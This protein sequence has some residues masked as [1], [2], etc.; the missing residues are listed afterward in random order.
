[1]NVT[2]N[3]FFEN[4]AMSYIKLEDNFAFDPE[5]IGPRKMDFH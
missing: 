1:M 2:K 5:F 4:S 3:V